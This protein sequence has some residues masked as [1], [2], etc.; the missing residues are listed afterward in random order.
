MLQWCGF[1]VRERDG[2]LENFLKSQY[3]GM[4]ETVEKLRETLL[5]ENAVSEAP[6]TTNGG[7]DDAD[8]QS[9]VTLP[10]RVFER[11]VKQ[12]NFVARQERKAFIKELKNQRVQLLGQDADNNSKRAR[13]S[14][15]DVVRRPRRL[16][17]GQ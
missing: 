6:S 14:F 10:V 1:L 4:Q 8:D 12:L 16:R 15:A 3:E 2:Q 7:G 11:F 13:P 9:V 5:S 17:P